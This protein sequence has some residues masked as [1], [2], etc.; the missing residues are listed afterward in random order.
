MTI[1]VI[2]DFPDV[3]PV[4]DCFELGYYCDSFITEIPQEAFGHPCLKS[5]II[6][7]CRLTTFPKDIGKL[8]HLEYLECYL[9]DID[10]IPTNFA[11][12]SNLQALSLEYNCLRDLPDSFANLNK[13]LYLDLSKNDFEHFPECLNKMKSLRVLN[14]C[15]TKIQ[16]AFIK[17]SQTLVNLYLMANQ[18]TQFI[19]EGLNHL[20]YLALSSNKLTQ[21]IVKERHNELIHLDLSNNLLE[22]FPVGI[23]LLP[24]LQTL[25]I[26][27]NKIKASIEAQKNLKK[28]KHLQADFDA[29][30]VESLK[31]MESL[32][33]VS[34]VIE[35]RHAEARKK[36]IENNRAVPLV[37]YINLEDQKKLKNLEDHFPSLCFQLDEY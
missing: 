27:G 13:L 31:Y 22:N 24:N 30:N 1:Y 18:L 25:K 33:K 16:S 3:W 23:A 19:L 37:N 6:N 15:F 7:E 32:D 9:N 36:H 34:L 29:I 5:L 17:N 20:R 14:L 28:L 35:A 8:E 12:L 11:E 10:S 26:G 2:D 4:D 21:F